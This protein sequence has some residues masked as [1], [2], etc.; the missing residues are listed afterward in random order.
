VRDRDW[1]AHRAAAA[2]PAAAR[3]ALGSA[4][5]AA[6]QSQPRARLPEA[7]LAYKDFWGGL[8]AVLALHFPSER[9]R[10]KVSQAFD[11]LHYAALREMNLEDVDD[12]AAMTARELGV[13]VR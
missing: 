11:E 13:P 2:T 1:V 7:G 9:E 4:P 10:K 8:D 6:A 12:V 3:A 5:P